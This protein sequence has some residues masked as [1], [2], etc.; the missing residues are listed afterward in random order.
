[1][2]LNFLSYEERN[3]IA[4]SQID[5]VVAFLKHS[6]DHFNRES[7]SRFVR[8]FRVELVDEQIDHVDD[9]SLIGGRGGTI[10]NPC[11]VACIHRSKQRL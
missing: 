8:V 1:M 7:P 5:F 9:T 10:A 6:L 11:G 2:S 4:I 3:F